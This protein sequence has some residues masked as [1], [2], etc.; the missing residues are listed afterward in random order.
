MNTGIRLGP[1][2][3]R[4]GDTQEEDATS[5]PSNKARAVGMGLDGM[6]QRSNCFLVMSVPEQ[7]E[8]EAGV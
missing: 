2:T 8:T 5:L 7:A 1:T 4:V 3:T 6:G